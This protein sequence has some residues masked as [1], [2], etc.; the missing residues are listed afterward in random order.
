MLNKVIKKFQEIDA[1]WTK[2]G[3]L[4]YFNA[5]VIFSVFLFSFSICVLLQ[6][7]LTKKSEFL[8]L[9]HEYLL[10]LAATTVVGSIVLTFVFIVF[11]AYVNTIIENKMQKKLNKLKRY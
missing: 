5:N 10:S 1:R 6:I 8:L 4:K 9:E 3:R 2:K 7:F 11:T